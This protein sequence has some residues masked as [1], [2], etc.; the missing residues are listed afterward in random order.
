MAVCWEGVGEGFRT[1]DPFETIKRGINTEETKVRAGHV[2]E[3]LGM[4][5]K[6]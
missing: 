4:E 5:E 2:A 6:T 1:K 3:G